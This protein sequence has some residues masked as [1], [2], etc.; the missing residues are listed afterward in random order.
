MD[1][2]QN[3]HLGLNIIDY[4]ELFCEL[5]FLLTVPYTFHRGGAASFLRLWP[6]KVR[7]FDVAII[8]SAPFISLSKGVT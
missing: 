1:N 8:I 3:F 6:A 5:M 7:E 4:F 2:P